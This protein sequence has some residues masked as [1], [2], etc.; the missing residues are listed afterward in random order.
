MT[1]VDDDDDDNAG[2]HSTATR[3]TYRQL[4]WDFLLLRRVRSTCVLTVLCAYLGTA[5]TA[6]AMA[7]CTTGTITSAAVEN[8]AARRTVAAPAAAAT[9]STTTRRRSAAREWSDPS[10][11]TATHAAATRPSTTTDSPSAVAALCRSEMGQLH[12]LQ[13]G[14]SR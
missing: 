8:C 6:A 10:P 13:E 12:F 3:A 4:L 1:D 11:S 2:H 7:L 14:N 9:T 5:R